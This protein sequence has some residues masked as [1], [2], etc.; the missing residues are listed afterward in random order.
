MN[1]AKLKEAVDN[2]VDCVIEAD[3]L[4]KN[5]CVALQINHSGTEAVC[6]TDEI[7]IHWDNNGFA[8]G[9]VITAYTE[10]PDDK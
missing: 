2:A 4:P 8:S 5:I 3:Q 7:E 10:N 9:C 6:A 1:L